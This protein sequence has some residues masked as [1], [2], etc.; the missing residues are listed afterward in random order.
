MSRGSQKRQHVGFCWSVSIAQG[1]TFEAHLS[2]TFLGVLWN[3]GKS[4]VLL[5]GLAVANIGIVVPYSWWILRRA[6]QGF[7]QLTILDWLWD[8]FCISRDTNRSSR[9]MTSWRIAVSVKANRDEQTLR[10]LSNSNRKY[11]R[12]F[13][14]SC[15]H[16]FLCPHRPQSYRLQAG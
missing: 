14:P 5:I 7:S 12:R 8:P 16:F 13:L 11:I 2:P 10:G 6:R 9:T 3:N 4:A 1:T 15:H